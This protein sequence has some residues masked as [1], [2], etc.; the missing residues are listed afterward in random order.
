MNPPA[1]PM[2]QAS[3]VPLSTDAWRLL[4]EAEIDTIVRELRKNA[5]WAE[6]VE[7]DG[8]GALWVGGGRWP[9]A[10]GMASVVDDTQETQ[11]GGSEAVLGDGGA[12]PQQRAQSGPP[13][14]SAAK[15]ARYRQEFASRRTLG[16]AGVCIGLASFVDKGDDIADDEYALGR[17][18]MLESFLLLREAIN[19]VADPH[20]MDP[21]A[22][23]DPFF[24]VIRDPETT[25]P[26][27]RC[28][29]VSIQRF[30]SHGIVD[31]S[32][33][34]AVPALL[35]L[36]RAVTH[37]RFE[38]TDAA[39]DEAV[40]MQ[41]LNMLGTLV[42][43]PGGHHLNDVAVC[44]IME[45]VLSMSCQMRLSEMLRKSAE[46]TLFTLVTFV[47][48]RLNEMQ[49]EVGSG[50]DDSSAAEPAGGGALAHDAGEALMT[51]PSASS[52]LVNTDR[53]RPAS[54]MS[55]RDGA[56]I[57][58]SASTAPTEDPHV[59]SKSIASDA[60]PTPSVPGL[61]GAS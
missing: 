17:I 48:G 50:F 52:M 44:E 55:G 15:M 46:S 18:M 2:E 5:L 9:T 31:F 59:D 19:G 21:Q 22:I 57:P 16:K 60:D 37:C 28:T 11:A 38:A 39:S 3:F 13:A 32:Q 12:D 6:A 25:G 43:S 7:R 26:I 58:A 10:Q 20:I 8:V 24:M 53:S 49:H 30:V 35:E 42:N 61:D 36:A 23:L 27:T 33:P 51:M 56:R 4:V 14:L 45:T 40:L 1:S 34:R 54:I 41:I 47:F 29:L